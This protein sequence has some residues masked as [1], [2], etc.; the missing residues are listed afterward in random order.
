MTDIKFLTLEQVKEITSISTAS[1]YRLMANDEFPQSVSIFG[2]RVAWLEHEVNAWVMSK[3][4]N[5]QLKT[6]NGKQVWEVEEGQ[7]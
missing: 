7:Y 1:I 3:A 4:L 6:I 5:A 2:R